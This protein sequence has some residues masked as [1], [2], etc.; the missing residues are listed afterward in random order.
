MD[1]LSKPKRVFIKVL[2]VLMVVSTIML[3][4]APLANF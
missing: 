4:L 1:H 2:A 3:L